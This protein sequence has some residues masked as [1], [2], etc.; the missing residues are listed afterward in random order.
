[1]PIGLCPLQIGMLK[2][3]KVYSDMALKFNKALT[4]IYI[5]H[6]IDHVVMITLQTERL[7]RDE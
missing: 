3:Y 4:Y 2:I 5:A 7:Q 1:M 6:M